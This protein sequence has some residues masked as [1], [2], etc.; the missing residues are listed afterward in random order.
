ML[1]EAFTIK[2]VE[3]YGKNRRF[4]EGFTLE[5]RSECS[6]CMIV[7]A[8]SRYF[9]T[10]PPTVSFALVDETDPER[11]LYRSHKY[12]VG[13]C[14]EWTRQQWRVPPMWHPTLY[15]VI[16]VEIPEGTTLEL[17]DFHNG[18]SSAVKPWPG[19]G[20]RHN[21]HLGFLGA[22]PSNSRLALE[23]AA[24]CG[25]SSCIVNIKQTRTIPPSISSARTP[26]DGVLPSRSWIPSTWRI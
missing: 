11:M 18:Y 8:L 19:S 20:P 13:L 22:G 23:L 6:D 3:R 24:Q 25:F 14:E 1:S 10:L 5:I 2:D 17:G 15:A 4:T 12:D 16:T 26:R 21:A 7:T 9:G